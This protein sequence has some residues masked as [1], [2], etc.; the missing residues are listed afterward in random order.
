[1]ILS[2]LGEADQAIVHLKEAARLSPRDSIM[3]FWHMGLVWA[4][5]IEGRYQEAAEA[6]QQAIRIAPQ[7]PTFRRQLASCYALQGRME[8]ARVALRDY[9]RLEPNHTIADASKVPTKIPEHLERFVEGL[10]RAGL[11]D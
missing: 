9:L 8:E 10:R 6:A 2:L 3:A 1:M 5:L 11:P 4:H 7:N